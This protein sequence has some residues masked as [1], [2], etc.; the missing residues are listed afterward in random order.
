MSI[1]DAVSTI[2]SRAIP[3]TVV[4]GFVKALA[5]ELSKGR[6][7][8]PSVPDIVIKVQRALAN[9]NVSNEIVVKVL[10]S[11][12]MLASKLLSMA[13]S[14]ALNTS[15][16]KIADLRMAVARVGFNI[17]RS[18]ALSFAVEQLKSAAEFKHLVPVL[19]VV[20]EHFL[21]RHDLR[22]QLRRV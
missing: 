18:A 7:D 10:G 9:E 20:Q 6:V 15:G 14:A 13:N 11:E 22:N 21:E 8:L 17:V 3:N 12:P 5:Q 4:F 16:R 19:D 2:E 1:P